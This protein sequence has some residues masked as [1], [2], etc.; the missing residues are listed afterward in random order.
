M[1]CSTV[2]A[3]R[4]PS[5][6][7]RESR[8]HSKAECRLHPS[9]DECIAKKTNANTLLLAVAGCPSSHVTPTCTCGDVSGVNAVI[10]G[11]PG[12]WST[13]TPGSTRVAPSRAEGRGDLQQG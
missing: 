6:D 13:A 10:V 12:A 4:K 8:T 2:G 5:F 11:M 9:D 7:S 3:K 1:R